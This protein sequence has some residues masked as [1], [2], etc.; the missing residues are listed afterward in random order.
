MNKIEWFGELPSTWDVTRLK[1]VLIERNESNKPVKTDFIL[2]LTNDRGVIP[3]SEKGAVGNNSKD[4]ITGYKLAYPKDL[5]LNSMNVVIGS[6]G[7]SKYFG[8]VSPVYYML[9]PRNHED[10]VEFYNYLFQT[11]EMQ[12]ALKGYGNGIMEIRMRI[13][14]SKLNTFNL[15]IPSSQVQ[16]KIVDR[17]RESENRIDQLIA[18]Q[19]QQIEKLKEYKQSLIT[20]VV[21]KGL[22]PNVEFK[23]SGIEW[24]GKIPAHWKMV[25]LSSIFYEHKLKNANLVNTNLLSLSYGNIVN[26]D[27]N[28]RD[29]LLPD[30][31]EGYNIVSNNDIV[32]RLTD[33]QNDKKS[34]RVG[35]CTQEGIITS[36]YITIRAKVDLNSYYFHKLL[37]SYDINKVF[38]G[39]GSGVRQSMGFNEIRKIPLLLPPKNEMKIISERVQETVCK[40]DALIT[41][42]ESKLEKLIDY[43]KSLIYEYVTGKKEVS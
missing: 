12:S 42:K 15:P 18:N 27:I 10:P 35:L 19:Q 32:L 25:F 37:H 36:A 40:I 7:I 21:T 6:V 4:D 26:K 33:L 8:C 31:F 14:M 38:Y 39:M 3:Y 20:E 5:V 28:T 11:N 24:I 22:D 2:S 41:L 29:G 34:L 30:S 16:R 23:E 9:R 1:N 13:A 43:K 17:I